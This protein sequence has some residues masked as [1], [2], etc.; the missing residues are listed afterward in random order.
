MRMQEQRRGKRRYKICRA[1][2][3]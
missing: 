2:E 1:S 3:M